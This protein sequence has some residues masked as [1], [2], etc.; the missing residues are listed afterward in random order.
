MLL[1][2]TDANGKVVLEFEHAAILE[3]ANVALDEADVVRD[4]EARVDA[5]RVLGADLVAEEGHVDAD[6]LVVDVVV[7]DNLLCRTAGVSAMA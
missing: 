3:D 6:F 4:L 2:R 5:R 7:A 1:K